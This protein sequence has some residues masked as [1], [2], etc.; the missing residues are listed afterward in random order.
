MR[1]KLV[2]LLALAA[3]LAFLGGVL[4]PSP[5]KAIA[6]SATMTTLAGGT[7]VNH[8][9]VSINGISIGDTTDALAK[10]LQNGTTPIA[11]EG[12]LTLNVST[13]GPSPIGQTTFSGTTTAFLHTGTELVGPYEVYVPIDYVIVSTSYDPVTGT[14]SVVITLIDQPDH[15]VS[16]VLG[17]SPFGSACG[18]HALVTRTGNS[19]GAGPSSLVIDHSK[20][21]RGLGDQRDQILR[22]G[23][24]VTSAG[25]N[26]SV[27]DAKGT[28]P[29]A[30]EP[31]VAHGD[32]GL[33]ADSSAVGWLA[34]VV[35][36]IVV[37][38]VAGLMSWKFARR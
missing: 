37:F 26:G 7:F 25:D 27:I 38:A 33:A 4:G 29:Q 16:F 2:T 20:Y 1:M 18:S 22:P 34:I 9:T 31:L 14:A 6:Q 19:C 30:P 23:V 21:L 24:L 3:A 32:A 17:T 13:N 8:A 12:P 5:P 10:R 11:G 28:T 15:P 35:W 36:P